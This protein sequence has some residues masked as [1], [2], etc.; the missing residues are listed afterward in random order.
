M[1]IADDVPSVFGIPVA[2]QRAL[3]LGVAAGSP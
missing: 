3:P 1:T 2:G